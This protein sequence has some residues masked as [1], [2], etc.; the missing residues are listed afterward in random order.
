MKRLESDGLT[1][2]VAKPTVIEPESLC[3]SSNEVL[4]TINDI[5]KVI[6]MCNHALHKSNV[7]AKP[8]QAQITFVKMID[9]SNYL[10]RLMGNEALRDKLVEHVQPI[11]KLLSHPA[12]EIYPQIQ[13][14]L[15]LIEVLHGYCFFIKSRSFIPS[16][17]PA[18]NLG[19]LSPRAFIPYDHTTPP[20]PKYFRQ[21]ILNSFPAEEVR[22]DFLN[23][24]FQCL[25]SFNMPHKVRELVVAGPVA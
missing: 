18:S 21:G 4:K 6:Q 3:S 16:P 19:K 10:H 14:D 2:N 1:L 23:K 9:V 15:D 24:F 20:Q 5:Q 17:I 13:F 7:Y 25:L 8:Q 12:R 22:V 11:Q